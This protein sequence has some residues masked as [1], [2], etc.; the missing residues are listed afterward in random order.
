MTSCEKFVYKISMRM[1]KRDNGIY[2]AQIK[3]GKKISLNTRN[4]DT[5]RR[6]FNK[7]QRKYWEGKLIELTGEKQSRSTLDEFAK[8][9]K[10]WAREV[11]PKATYNADC[12]ALNQLINTHGDSIYLASLSQ[13]HLDQIISSC[14][15]RKLSAASIN[16]Y[17]RHLRSVFNKA[18][19][20]GCLK[21][22]PFKQSK[23]IP[24]EKRPPNYINKDHLSKLFKSIPDLELRKLIAAYLATGRRRK[25]L[26]NLTWQDI[27]WDKGRYF[28]R[29]SKTHL[30]R[31]YPISKTFKS[32]LESMEPKDS[33]YIWD[34]W[35]HP[36]TVSKK[37]KQAF[38]DAGL[39]H[40]RLHDLR[41]TFATH[42]VESGGDLRT[43]QDLL[44][45]TEYRTTEIYAHIS[46]QHQA[47]EIERVKL[48]PIDLNDPDYD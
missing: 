32:I 36:D 2:Y 43:L 30:S 24:A 4:A 28:V 47:Q 45:H 22:N 21:V 13:K 31:Y 42:F 39:S 34:K 37:V 1:F 44:G 8:E 27:E 29:K 26:L 11:K 17:I 19:E 10:S 35:Q 25:E 41:H 46:E 48:G 16:N 15:Q 7:L 18:V 12:L 20:W 5:A 3:R 23:E 38:R 14:K 40:L 9:Y 6:R 33:G